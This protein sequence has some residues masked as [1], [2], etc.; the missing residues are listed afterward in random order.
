MKNAAEIAHGPMIIGLYINIILLGIIATQMYM[1]LN[2]YRK[3]R[4]WMKIF[5]VV[6]FVANVANT[7]FLCKFL[8]TSLIL[9]FGDDA[10]LARADWVF[11]TDPALTGII[12][13][14]V[15]LFFAWRVKVLTNN[16][17]LVGIV[18]VCALAGTGAAIATSFEVGN[19]P[20]FVKFQ[21]FKVVVII[22][23]AAECISDILISGIL[24][25][26][27]KRRK[28]GF[29]STDE[30]VDRIIRLT[31]QTGL[32]TSICAIIDLALFLSDPTG[33]HLIFNFPLSKLYTNTMMSTLNSRRGWDFSDQESTSHTH[34][35]SGIVGE[36]GKKKRIFRLDTS[37]TTRPQVFVDVEQ[38]VEQHEMHTRNLADRH[39]HAN[40]D[41][42]VKSAS[43]DDSLT[44]AALPRA[45]W[46]K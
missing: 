44:A 8:Y 6:L 37:Q 18:A 22:W 40:D 1:Y 35:T 31:V 13:G 23:L 25:W 43:P 30:L 26:Q 38:H 21:D 19:T 33:T 12:A 16:L 17:W 34:T 4:L 42:D 20:E 39:H 36:R 29:Q 15:Q 10:Y 7:A 2:A 28:T 14:M 5:V 32:I 27:L 41:Y 3:D 24:V 11:A 9:N 45:P 46:E